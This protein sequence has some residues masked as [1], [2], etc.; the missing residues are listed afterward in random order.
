[1]K[2]R[3]EKQQQAYD[4]LQKLPQV[5]LVAKDIPDNG[6]WYEKLAFCIINDYLFV[7]VSDIVFNATSVMRKHLDAGEIS[8]EEM[9]PV[10]SVGQRY[11]GSAIWVVSVGVIIRYETELNKMS[12]YSR[13]KINFARAYLDENNI[14]ELN[15]YTLTEEQISDAHSYYQERVRLLNE[16][17]NDA[18]EKMRESRKPFEPIE[19]VSMPVAPTAPAADGL[20]LEQLVDR[21][22]SMGWT[23]TLHR[24][25][26]QPADATECQAPVAAKITVPSW[27]N[28]DIYQMFGKELKDFNL[29]YGTITV[30]ENV[31]ITTLGQIVSMTKTDLLRIKHFGKKKLTELD[32]MFEELGLEFDQDINKWHEARK[33][34]LALNGG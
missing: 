18:A 17:Q 24:K 34:F 8:K 5:M 15:S 13:P 1:M 16:V 23:V 6:W 2:V 14:D 20:T 30:L 19:S 27:Y 33:A 22:E 31:G 11:G 28:D 32:D 10:R 25:E 4:M 26:G 12:S 7:R 21:I 29:S 3:N 9:I